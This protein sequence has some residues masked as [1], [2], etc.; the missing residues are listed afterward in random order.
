MEDTTAS[1]LQSALL[2]AL[3]Q[4][5]SQMVTTL[6]VWVQAAPRTLADLEARILPLAQTVGQALL[7]GACQLLDAGPSVRSQPCACG[8]QATYQRQRGATVRTVLG[9]VTIARAYY[10]CAT[11]G[12]G[13]AP[14]DQQLG[15][16]AGSTSAGLDELLALVGALADSFEEA[17]T[18]LGK[19]TLVQV[20]PN[21]ARTA[22]ERLGT[23][24][25]A[26][27]EV[28]R[29]SAWEDGTLPLA[30]SPPARLSLSLD[31]VL[32]HTD[33]GWREYKLGTAYTTRT[34]PDKD[35]PGE[36]EVV[37][38]EQ[39]YIGD[40]VDAA[41]IGQLWWCEAARRGALEAKELVV[42]ADGAH[43]IWDLVAEHFPDATQI[44]DWYHASGYIWQ[45]AHAS[46][47]EGS[48]LGKRWAKKRL[49]E[50]W[51][52]QVPAVLAAFACKTAHGKAVA[53]AITYFTNQQ[54]RMH[55]A[56]YRARGLQIG[57]GTME[58][59]CKQ[60][61]TARLKQAGMIWSINGARAVA[62]VRA[63]LKSGRWQEA[64]AL[65]PPRRRTYQRRAA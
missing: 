36:L 64:I 17:A 18:L 43:W 9:T 4:Q 61:I 11:C 22:T 48:D 12:Q 31:G 44:V 53:E 2:T 57:S 52:G 16:C 7:T 30:V 56:D 5:I 49:D 51:A 63:W 33:D 14:L 38:Q 34:R 28:T 26:C 58:S 13:Q 42:V 21:L 60:I 15:Y 3:T 46:Y 62:T 29:A 37:A 59:S 54:A 6:S 50:L 25:Q 23:Q 8:A 1:P 19:L 47:G 10:H 24:L 39:T 27:Q 45:V 35:H 55:Y 65:R 20:C 40:L 41:T 32:V